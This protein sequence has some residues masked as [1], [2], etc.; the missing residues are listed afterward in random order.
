MNRLHKFG[1]GLSF[2][3]CTYRRI[4]LFALLNGP[5]TL[6]ARIALVPADP[7][8]IFAIDAAQ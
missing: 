6:Y 2:V 8:E 5:D 4:C 3:S 7:T 1:L